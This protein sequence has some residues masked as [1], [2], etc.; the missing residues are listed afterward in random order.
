MYL[1]T[2]AHTVCGPCDYVAGS[3]APIVWW[4][5]SSSTTSRKVASRFLDASGKGTLFKTRVATAR[6]IQPFSAIQKEFELLML[7]GT[8][9]KVVS[10]TTDAGLTTIVLEEDVDAPDMIDSGDDTYEFVELFK[11][12]SFYEVV[13]PGAYENV[14]LKGSAPLLPP[15]LVKQP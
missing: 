9:L 12:K 6:D 13:T 14:S 1:H 8:P 11:S 15:K 4:P 7:P 3:S 10:V 5:F 2:L